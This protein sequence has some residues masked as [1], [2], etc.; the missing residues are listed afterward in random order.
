MS[1]YLKP[2]MYAVIW[3]VLVGGLGVAYAAEQMGLGTLVFLELC[4][5]MLG[6]VAVVLWRRMMNPPESVEEL[7]YETEHAN[8]R[9]A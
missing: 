4:A 3:L 9:N 5:V 7:L 6:I 2:W 8:R 1:R